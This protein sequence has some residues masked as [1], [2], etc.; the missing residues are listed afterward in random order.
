ME[1]IRGIDTL[2]DKEIIRMVDHLLKVSRLKVHEVELMESG[3][4][5]YRKIE[6]KSA[7]IVDGIICR[8]SYAEDVSFKKD[9]SCVHLRRWYR[10]CF[11]SSGQPYQVHGRI[12]KPVEFKL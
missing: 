1:R 11:Y 3:D 2:T 4:M 8:V 9:V 10:R 5:Y 12:C 6:V 7:P